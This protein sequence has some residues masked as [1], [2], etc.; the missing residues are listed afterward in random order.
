MFYCPNH[1]EVR[2]KV[3]TGKKPDKITV[4]SGGRVFDF[5]VNSAQQ[6]HEQSGLIEMVGDF[7]NRSGRG[8]IDNRG[9]FHFQEGTLAPLTPQD[10]SHEV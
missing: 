6:V 10:R 5:R 4:R 2:D 1:K 8:W 3:K 9:G 7:E